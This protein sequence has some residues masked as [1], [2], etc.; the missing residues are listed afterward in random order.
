MILSFEVL[1]IL[2]YQQV[3]QGSGSQQHPGMLSTLQDQAWPIWLLVDHFQGLL[4]L[5]TGPSQG[6]HPPSASG[7][8][9]NHNMAD[10]PLGLG[11]LKMVAWPF[12]TDS[13]RVVVDLPTEISSH[14][15]HACSLQGQLHV[16]STRTPHLPPLFLELIPS[17]WIAVRSPQLMQIKYKKAFN[18]VNVWRMNV[19]LLSR[20]ILLALQY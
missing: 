18:M 8:G 5:Q 12:H 16:L 14:F 1:L 7:V 15:K 9:D 13:S 10:G 3:Q 2:H 20:A 4:Q 6:E 17:L 19:C 11:W